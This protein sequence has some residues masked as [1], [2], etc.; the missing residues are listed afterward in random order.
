MYIDVSPR[1]PSPRSHTTDQ[2]KK[3]KSN[4]KLVKSPPKQK[5][6]THQHV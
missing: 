2:S 5:K 1:I 4:F 3:K 6:Q